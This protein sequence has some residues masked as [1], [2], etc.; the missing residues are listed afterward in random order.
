M[1]ERPLEDSIR[2]SLRAAAPRDLPPHLFDAVSAIPRSAEIPARRPR[3]RLGLGS[4]FAVFLTLTVMASVALLAPRATSLF[5]APSLGPKPS[6]TFAA[7]SS[8][9]PVT[10]CGVVPPSYKGV[11]IPFLQCDDAIS[12]ALT[13]LPK[14]HA[15]I[16][17]IEF[18]F[19][20]YCAAT[21]ACATGIDLLKGWVVVSYASGPRT[22]VLVRDESAQSGVSVTGSETLP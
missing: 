9:G 21:A 14:E 1:N 5:G 11:F 4:A 19:G 15:E 10:I 17:R 13:S 3:L 16:A 6:A 7:A 18:G 8:G 12:A 20:D 22:L 2:S